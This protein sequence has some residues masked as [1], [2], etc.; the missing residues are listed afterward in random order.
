M[1]LNLDE[2]EEKLSHN[3]ELIFWV[4]YLLVPLIT[5]L[6][7]Y[8]WLPNEAYSPE[9]H[10]L[11]AS[12]EIS[13]NEGRTG[14]VYDV[15]KDKKTGRI[16]RLEDLEEHRRSER[17]RMTYTCFMYG[18]LG[19]VFFAFTQSRF[20]GKKFTVSLAQAMAVNLAVALFMYFSV[21]QL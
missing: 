20:A 15:W 6:L 4:L 18:L 9:R 21:F 12:H 13:D 3:A 7:A 14:T 10:E 8:N 11:I 17:V 5:G 19:G 2:L 1:R 16:F